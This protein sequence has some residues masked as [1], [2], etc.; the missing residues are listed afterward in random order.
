MG[1]VCYKVLAGSIKWAD[2]LSERR[3]W[4]AAYGCLLQRDS[5]YFYYSETY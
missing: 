2:G 1:Y 3:L 4:L 5:F